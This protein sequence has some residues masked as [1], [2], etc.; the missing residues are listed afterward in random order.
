MSVRLKDHRGE[1]NTHQMKLLK[2]R[3]RIATPVNLTTSVRFELNSLIYIGNM[4]AR[5]KGPNPCVNDTLV[6]AMIVNA[7][8]FVDQFFHDRALSAAATDMTSTFSCLHLPTGHG[9]LLRAVE[10]ARGSRL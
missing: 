1:L 6:E 9:G 5:D 4:G 7:F 3:T 10:P 2:P 8:H